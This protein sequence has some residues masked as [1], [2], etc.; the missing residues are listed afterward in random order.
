MHKAMSIA[1][2]LL[3]AAVLAWPQHGRQGPSGSHGQ[4]GPQDGSQFGAAASIYDS[5]TACWSFNNTSDL[6]NDDCATYD[7]TLVNT[8]VGTGGANGYAAQFAQASGQ[9]ANGADVLSI[10]DGDVQA[11][12]AWVKVDTLTN[13][14]ILSKDE[15]GDSVEEYDFYLSVTTGYPNFRIWGD[16]TNTTATHATNAGDGGRHLVMG[17]YDSSD[18]KT[19]VTVDAETP[20]AS[21]ALPTGV[22]DAGTALFKVADSRYLPLFD[23]N[24]G[25][26]MAWDGIPD[27]ATRTSLYNSG[28]GKTCADLAG[29][30]LTN[31]VSCWEMDEDGGPYADSIGSNNLTGVN[32]PT[33]AAG[34]VER[35]DSGMGFDAGT[36]A[37]FQA[38]TIVGTG[39]FTVC[40]WSA[41]PLS[42]TH[43]IAQESAG[44]T[45]EFIFYGHST[46]GGRYYIEVYDSSSGSSAVVQDSLGLTAEWRLICG[47]YTES[48][49]KS[50]IS[51][52]AADKTVSS[53]ALSNG[54]RNT[55]TNFFVSNGAA[56]S[57][58]D[59]TAVWLKELTDADIDALYD[60]GAGDFYAFNYFDNLEGILFG[61]VRYAWYDAPPRRIYVVR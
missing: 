5:A 42:N 47:G 37:Y 56:I 14:A 35:S 18:R 39:D 33:R 38:S 50:W 57:S 20:T 11:F 54:K 8:P 53:T 27:A 21:T 6:G 19:Y 40:T 10:A 16:S 25:P 29:A 34:L 28:K 44:A 7:L 2:V 45:H 61:G 43:Y 30:E 60:S 41:E 36:T 46:T 24:V 1:S 59:N 32:T 23:G 22:L 4:P 17:W 26:V 31:L 49:K 51:V 55:G 12:A 48:T 3:L 58:G 15:G 9:A 52:N 13:L